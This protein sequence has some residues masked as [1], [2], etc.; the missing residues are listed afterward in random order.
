MCLLLCQLRICFG[1]G[2]LRFG[3]NGEFKILQVAD[4]HYADGKKTLCEDV[5]PQQ[6]KTCSDLNTTA[7][8]QRMI[9]KEKPHLIV[10]TGLC[11][12]CLDIFHFMCVLSEL[13]RSCI[14]L[15]YCTNF[16]RTKRVTDYKISMIFLAYLG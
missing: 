12:F 8:I 5:L 13:G 6:M 16:F 11:F 3:K 2:K 4:M 7:F 1:D 10:F 14:K 9:L 15:L